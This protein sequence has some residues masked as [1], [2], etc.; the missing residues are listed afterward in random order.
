MNKSVGV[1]CSPNSKLIAVSLLD[2]TVKLF[3]F[4]T[5]NF[6]VSLYGHRLPVLSFDFSTDSTL[7]VTGSADKNIKVN[8]Q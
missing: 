5:L 1:R 3:Y 8:K 2:N 7:I 4:E 6:F